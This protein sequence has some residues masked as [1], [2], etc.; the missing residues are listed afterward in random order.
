MWINF[1]CVVN[2]LDLLMNELCTYQT[3]GNEVFQYDNDAMDM[4]ISA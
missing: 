3:N 1:R 4:L 2:H